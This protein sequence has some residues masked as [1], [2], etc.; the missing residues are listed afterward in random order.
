MALGARTTVTGQPSHRTAVVHAIVT[1][2]LA[3]VGPAP[4]SIVDAGGGTGGLAVPLAVAGH[5][6]TVVDP[7]PDSLAASGRRAAEAGVGDRI[8]VVQG[9][10]DDLPG[11][12]T[13]GSADAV[14]CHRVLEFVDDRAAALAHVT[15]ALRPGGLASLLVANRLAQVIQRALAG[16]FAEAAESLSPQPAPG[17]LDRA[18][19]EALVAAAGLTVAGVHGV[20]VVSDL[21][22]GALLDDPEAV[23]GVVALEQAAADHPALR[24]VATQLHVLAHKPR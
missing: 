10:L 14:L 19:L 8:T 23:A 21:V 6:V 12:V 5:H 1:R 2:A 18:E 4:L 15:S 13:A 3:E 17:P 24:E 7:S 20:R 16:R 9:D 22:P 11:V